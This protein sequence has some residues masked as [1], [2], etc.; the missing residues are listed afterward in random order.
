[1]GGPVG[2]FLGALYINDGNDHLVDEEESVFGPDV[3]VVKF[4]EVGVGIL[5]HVGQK[6]PRIVCDIVAVS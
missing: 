2:I 1:M 3:G 6:I 4:I 5:V